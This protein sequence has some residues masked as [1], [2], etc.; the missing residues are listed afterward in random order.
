VK[1]AMIAGNVYEILKEPLGIGREARWVNGILQ[2]PP[3]YCPRISLTADS[4]QLSA[5]RNP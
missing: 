3:L 1:D 2:T 4:S 5:L